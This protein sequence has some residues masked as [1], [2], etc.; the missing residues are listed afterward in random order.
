[1]SPAK[2]TTSGDKK[3]KQTPAKLSNTAL[4]ALSD[5][6]L[7][8]ALA[9]VNQV[10]PP[11]YVSVNKRGQVVVGRDKEAVDAEKE[12]FLWDPLSAEAGYI[13]WKD[14][15]P[16]EERMVSVFDDPV[17]PETL[18][19]H[20]PYEQGDGWREQVKILGD[21]LATGQRV[22]YSPTSY[23]GRK[24]VGAMQKKALLD[25][26]EQGRKDL[27]VIASWHLGSYDHSKYG[28]VL[29]ADLV[30]EAIVPGA[31]ASEKALS[32]L[33]GGKAA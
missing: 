30:V 15:S 12:L 27:V 4:Q 21:R 29:T 5:S 10:D 11:A 1:M 13:C 23:G 17:S 6:A 18:T 2:T 7:D 3:A 25:M 24:T 33:N 14:G 32:L 28:E 20:G 8:R 16:V 19:D 22:V 26:K 9:Q 31:E